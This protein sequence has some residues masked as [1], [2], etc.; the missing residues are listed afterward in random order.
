MCFAGIAP[1]KPYRYVSCYTS[2][3]PQKEYRLR[4]DVDGNFHFWNVDSEGNI[5][6]ITPDGSIGANPSRIRD[7]P[8]YIPWSLKEQEKQTANMIAGL[9]GSGTEDDF[10]HASLREH[11]DDPGEKYCFLN[12]K[13]VMKYQGHKQVCGSMGYIIGEESEFFVV[14]LDYGY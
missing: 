5:I 8:V 2:T 14:S 1:L 12:S 11:Y 6:D 10:T 7:K 4:P 13:A 9:D 3:V